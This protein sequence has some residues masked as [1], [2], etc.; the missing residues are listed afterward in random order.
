MQQTALDGCYGSYAEYTADELDGKI[1]YLVELGPTLGTVRLLV[2]PGKEIGTVELIDPITRDV[3][4][5]FL[6]SP[7]E[8]LFV[9]NGAI[10]ERGQFVAAPGGKVTAATAGTG[11]RLLGIKKSPLS[12]GAAGDIITGIV[13]RGA[14][15]GQVRAVF[16]PTANAGERTVGAHGLGVFLPDDAIIT[17]FFLEVNNTFTSADDSATIAYHAEGAGD[18]LAAI[19]ISDATN[20]H[21]AGL[22]A[23]K[24]GY[25]NFG[26]DAAHDSQV[27]VAA[28]FAGTFI[29]LTAERELTATVAGQALTGGKAT[30]FVD[31]TRGA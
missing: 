3:R 10:A 1:N 14:L 16:N 31:Y 28:L 7:G 19:A 9:Q 15:S 5:R 13:S 8:H 2:T 11:D 29:K 24:P 23:G 20:V 6:N 27:E 21:D 22:H 4:V 17:R 30:L 26:A 25:P 12:N 18:L